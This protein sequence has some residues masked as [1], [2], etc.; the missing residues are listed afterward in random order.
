MPNS[1][2]ESKREKLYHASANN[3]NANGA[4]KAAVLINFSRRVMFETKIPNMPKARRKIAGN[5]KM[6]LVPM[7]NANKVLAR[8]NLVNDL[9][10]VSHARYSMKNPVRKKNWPPAMAA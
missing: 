7:E 8:D 10:P 9:K 1:N 5:T 2:G 3:P 6:F 4:L